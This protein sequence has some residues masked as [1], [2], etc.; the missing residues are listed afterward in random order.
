MRG[1]ML[2]PN[3]NE[4][5]STLTSETRDINLTRRNHCPVQKSKNFTSGLSCK[6]IIFGQK[7]VTIALYNGKSN[8][9]A[10]AHSCWD[11][12]WVEHEENMGANRCVE[13]SSTFNL[14]WSYFLHDKTAANFEADGWQKGGRAVC[15]SSS[16]SG[17]ACWNTRAPISKH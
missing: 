12:R 11:V 16:Q 2:T 10:E 3:P 1:E 13:K 15:W 7:N 17:N 6:V 9:L 5:N 8:L 14:S 4:C